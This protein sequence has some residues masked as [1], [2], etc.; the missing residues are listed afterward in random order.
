[1]GPNSMTD[2]LIRRRKY[3]YR[4]TDCGKMEAEVRVMQ[5]IRQGTPRNAGNHQNVGRGKED[6]PLRPAE[7][8]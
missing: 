3:G 4:C 5:S 1:M 8:A 7:I 6:N 2:V